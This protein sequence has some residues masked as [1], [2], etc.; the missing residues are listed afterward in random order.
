MRAKVCSVLSCPE[1]CPAQSGPSVNTSWV[2]TESCLRH[3]GVLEEGSAD[4][5]EG[6][7]RR[8]RLEGTQKSPRAFSLSHAAVP[9]SDSDHPQLREPLPSKRKPGP[10]LRFSQ[11]G[12]PGWG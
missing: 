3:A 12:D 6:Q 10:G 5:G 11:A 7:G 2:A 4:L 9:W 1:Q 8:P